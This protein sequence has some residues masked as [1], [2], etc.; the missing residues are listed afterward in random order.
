MVEVLKRNYLSGATLTLVNTIE[1]IDQIWMRIF[2]SFGNTN[3]LLRNKLGVLEKLG[4]LWKAKS[5]EKIGLAIAG[6]LNAMTQL[7]LGEKA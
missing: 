4:G 6:L 2:K 7:Q 3:L 1:D 5:D